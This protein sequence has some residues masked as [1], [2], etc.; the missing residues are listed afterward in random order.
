MY[1]SDFPCV[2]CLECWE[3]FRR[4]RISTLSF[5]T[6]NRCI[7]VLLSLRKMG[8]SRKVAHVLYCHVKLAFLLT[9]PVFGSTFGGPHWPW[10]MSSSLHN[11]PDLCCD[12]HL[13]FCQ[14]V[15]LLSLCR[16]G[17]TFWLLHFLQP[18]LILS[19]V[20]CLFCP[21]ESTLLSFIYLCLCKQI[22][23]NLF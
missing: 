9:V 21:V 4:N 14:V 17:W 1:L 13:F 5:I 12:I 19:A 18:T 3:E 22:F 23:N 20:C 6:V 7:T 8:L 11:T 2:Q 15:S 16:C 10:T